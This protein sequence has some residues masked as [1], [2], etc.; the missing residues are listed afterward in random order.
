MQLGSLL[1]SLP[2]RH[3]VTVKCDGLMTSCSANTLLKELPQS[4][5]NA[6]VTSIEA[7]G[8]GTEIRVRRK[9]KTGSFFG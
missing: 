6:T 1:K 5:L 2:K 7:Y 3:L 8:S 4:S 9:K